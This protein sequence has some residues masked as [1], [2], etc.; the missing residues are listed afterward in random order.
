MR[1]YISS[2]TLCFMILIRK[3][4]YYPHRSFQHTHTSTPTQTHTH[5]PFLTHAHTLSTRTFQHSHTLS[6]TH[7]SAGNPLGKL[8]DVALQIVFNFHLIHNGAQVS[9][10]INLGP[11]SHL[12]RCFLRRSA[13]PPVGVCGD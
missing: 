12:L 4:F 2:C 7:L 9:R 6:N 10:A 3:T 5:T 1:H 8:G 13:V 11:D